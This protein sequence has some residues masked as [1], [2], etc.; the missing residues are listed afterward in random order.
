MNLLKPSP[1]FALISVCSLLLLTR[2]SGF[3]G[4]CANCALPDPALS[5][6]NPAA[7]VQTLARDV[8]KVVPGARSRSRPRS[9]TKPRAPVP[10]GL[11]GSLAERI[12]DC[13]TQKQ[14]PAEVTG[15]FS[16]W[17]LVSRVL[18]KDGGFSEVW[19]DDAPGG[20][21]WGDTTEALTLADTFTRDEAGKVVEKACV[22]AST[23]TSRGNISDSNW[24]LA[25]PADFVSA[26]S[27]GLL[28]ALPNLQTSFWTAFEVDPE[29]GFQQV[30]NSYDGKIDT[31]IAVKGA[32]YSVRCVIRP[33]APP[34]AP[35]P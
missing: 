8:K 1:A 27:H 20:L 33:I 7:Q 35:S 19:K 5:K 26:Q 3:A 10:C 32:V 23:A 22:S 31:M 34:V 9:S 14:V 6:L 25:T 28:K 4:T 24:R 17:S 18:G 15:T 12:L 13:H 11:S 21:V 30:Y 29:Y 16:S 2:E